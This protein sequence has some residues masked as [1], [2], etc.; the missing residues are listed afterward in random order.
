VTGQ[1]LAQTVQWIRNPANNLPDVGI[2]DGFANQNP[3]VSGAT[4]P[5]G[6]T[7]IDKHP[8]HEQPYIFPGAQPFNTNQRPVNALGQ[9][10]GFQD[11]T[12]A[13]RD[14]F[15]PTYMA[16]FPEYTLSAI[17]TEFLERDLSPLTTTFNGAPHGRY[18]EPPGATTPP[19]EWITETNINQDQAA[20]WGLT[21]AD[22]W[23]LQAK[24]T[25]RTLA[26]FVNKGVSRIYFY[27]VNNGNL[28]MVEPNAPG[29]GP[30]MTAVKNF[31]GAFQGPDTITTPRSLS[32]LQIADQGNWT[33]F[34]GDGTPAH[35]PLYN[36]D[37]VAFFP[38]QVDNNKFVVPA[39]VMTRNIAKLY[40]PTAPTTDV[41]RYDLP[42]KPTASPSAG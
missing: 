32:L 11:S 12:G 21:T 22:Q 42:P 19:Q 36:R 33:Q 3:F 30:T 4:V 38:F 20:A 23:H 5:N 10:E 28:A 29:G 1:L 13:W 37:V 31:I 18:T 17:Q 8:Y 35:P 41:T 40:N 39:Y 24:A 9:P 6:V 2:G 16:Y 27:A 26:A 14:S 15:V 7:A 34:T 25:L